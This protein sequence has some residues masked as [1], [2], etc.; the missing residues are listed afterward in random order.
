MD[1]MMTL[2]T[3]LISRE[4]GR[5]ETAAHNI[6]NV[7]TPGYKREIAF[8]DVLASGR[9]TGATSSTT[10]LAPSGIAT[11]FSA[12]KLVHTGNPMDFSISGPGFFEVMTSSGA[13]YTRLGSFQ[14]DPDGRLVTAQGSPLQA[15]G[16]GD[17]VVGSN[18]WHIERDGTLIDDGNPSTAIR[19]A[20][21]S[22]Q[23]KLTRGEGGLFYANGAQAVDID[24]PQIVQAFVESSNV[25]VGNDMIQMMEAMRRVE[26]G[27]KLVHAYDDMVG[28]VLQRLGD[29]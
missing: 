5:V 8:E 13:A 23:A 1:N 2:A 24:Q 22:D 6:A 17:V 3:A 12:G 14:R 29:M 26:T 21:F 16:G 25:S 20:T 10:A 11:D 7:A 27:Q 28:G 19:V 4:T 15:V 9:S 18:N